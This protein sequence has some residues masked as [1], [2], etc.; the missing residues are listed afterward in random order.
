MLSGSP[1]MSQSLLSA[2]AAR[3]GGA[4]ILA[5]ADL[6]LAETPEAAMLIAPRSG[7]G[8]LLLAVDRALD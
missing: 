2:L 5:A 8:Q 6:L 7:V 4:V 3:N 1:R